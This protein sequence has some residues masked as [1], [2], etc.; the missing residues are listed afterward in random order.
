M[1][2]MTLQ[3]AHKTEVV[4]QPAPGKRYSEPTITVNGQTKLHVFDKFTYMGSTLFRSMHIVVEVTARTVTAN[5][6]FGRIRAK[7]WK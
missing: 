1:T 4:H 6:A 7:V 2:T 5:V 3:S